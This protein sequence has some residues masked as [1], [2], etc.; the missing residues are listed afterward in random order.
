MTEDAKRFGPRLRWLRENAGLTQAELAERAGLHSQGVVKLERG[1]REPAWSTLLA[2]AS[3]LGVSV[4][5]FTEESSSQPGLPPRPRG[6]KKPDSIEKPATKKPAA[7]PAK[8][9]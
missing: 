7:K 2:L 6:R 4:G 8:K 5:A 1:E 9:K 3:A